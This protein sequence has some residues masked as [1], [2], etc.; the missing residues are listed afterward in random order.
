MLEVMIR[1]RSVERRVEYINRKQVIEITTNL[2]VRCG[3]W[4]FIKF[5]FLGK[6]NREEILAEIFKDY[7]PVMLATFD[8]LHQVSFAGA[9]RLDCSG[10]PAEKKH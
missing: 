7:E 9:A 8:A 4:E 2:S 3:F 10:I 5:L 6:K 1:Q